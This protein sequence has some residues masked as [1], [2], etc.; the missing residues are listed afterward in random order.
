MSFKLSALV[1]AAA[2]VATASACSKNSESSNSSTTTTSTTQSSAPTL[3]TPSQAEPAGAPGVTGKPPSPAAVANGSS[4]SATT[5]NGK[6]DAGKGKQIFANNCSSCHGANGQGGGIGPSLIGER[7]RKNFDQTVTWIE[8]PQP[9][10][11][12]LYPAPLSLTDVKNV[13]AYVQT[14]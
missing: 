2:V 1:L 4:V 12:K 6:G 14:L 13:A 11:P 8:N 10:M 9:P 3:A 7:K 5:A